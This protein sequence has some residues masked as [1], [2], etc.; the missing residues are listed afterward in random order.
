MKKILPPIL[1]MQEAKQGKQKTRVLM[2]D[3]SQR[4][5]SV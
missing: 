4:D 2:D 3:L 1:K 5:G